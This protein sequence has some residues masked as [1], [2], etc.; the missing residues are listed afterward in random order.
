VSGFLVSLPVPPSV[1][2]LYGNAPSGRRHGRYKTRRYRAW[3]EEAGWE[4]LRQR[5]RPLIGPYSVRIS[6]PKIKGDPDN[7]IKPLLDI[8]V[9]HNLTD[10]DRHCKH[11]SATIIPELEKGIAVVSVEVIAVSAGERE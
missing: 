7:R 3:I 6:L 2:S 1:N 8:L 10:D 4:L 11:V 9:S 5:P